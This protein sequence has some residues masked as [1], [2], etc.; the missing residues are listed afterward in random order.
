MSETAKVKILSI[1]SGPEFYDGGKYKIWSYNVNAT[2]NGVPDT[3]I[4]KAFSE[5]QKECLKPGYEGEFDVDDYKGKISYKCPFIKKENY[6]SGKKGGDW[7]R[8][9]YSLEEFDALFVHACG[10]AV[11]GA[12]V[13]K[14]EPSHE[15]AATYI[16]SAT[17]AGVK[18][19]GTSPCQEA[20]PDS[21]AKVKVLLAGIDYKPVFTDPAVLVSMHE[22]APSDKAFVGQ[23]KMVVDGANPI[24]EEDNIPY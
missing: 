5:M 16:I 18:V 23:V 21:L 3:I 15:L 9:S 4:V 22:S 17:Q 20:K 8:P 19:G 12:T 7:G 6:F 13:L 14:I 2:V 11:R 10:A 24:E 1:Q